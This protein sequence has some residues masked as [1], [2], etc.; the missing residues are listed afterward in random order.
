MNR[1]TC[2]FVK[3]VNLNLSKDAPD[4]AVYRSKNM[5]FR[6]KAKPE[7]LTAFGEGHEVIQPPE[8]RAGVV[9]ASPHS[10]AIY[11]PDLLARSNLSA[12][13][14]RRNEDIFIDHLFQSAV[15]AG[16]PFIR[17]LFPRVI[18]DVNRAEYE[19]P[20]QWHAL[21]D[22]SGYQQP[23]PRA[24]AGLGV[25]PTYLSEKLPIYTRLPDIKDVSR[26][27]TRLYHP[28]HAAVTG[29]LETSVNRFGRALLVDCHSMPGFAPMGSRR[30]D[31]IL[32][33]RFGTS[34]HPDTLALFR[35]LFTQAGYS[36]GVNYPY[37]GGYTT[38]YYGKP[39][40]GIEAIQIEVNRDLYVNP[41]T[42]SPKSGYVQ[43]TED[44]R[45]ITYDI[46]ASA[47]PQA[48]AAQ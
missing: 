9:F 45:Q 1:P 16:A 37:A 36:V 33:D 19:L 43:L 44:L 6:N 21:I 32:G 20:P 41:V 17:A 46:V 35:Q 15:T 40:E 4:F 13:Q 12:H 47:M 8:W 23:T 34:C 48:L 39:D 7:T 3:P 38:S 18:V 27:L 24:A 29:L 2:S 31:I 10:G 14:L 11:P 25:V 42:L 22:N 26:R 28:Y 5:R 30:P